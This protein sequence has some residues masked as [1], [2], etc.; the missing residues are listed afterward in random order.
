MKNKNYSF[1]LLPMILII[2]ADRFSKSWALGLTDEKVINQFLSFGLTFNRGIN[3]G[4]FNSSD[5]AIFMVINSAIAAVIVGFGVYTYYCWKLRQS[6]LGNTLILAGAFSNYYDRMVHGGVID[7]IILSYGNWSWPAFNIAD[8][9]NL[10][11]DWI[12]FA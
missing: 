5:T 1:Y 7:F 11:R 3:W 2:L 6:I 9:G 4:F 8:A 12:D 10:L